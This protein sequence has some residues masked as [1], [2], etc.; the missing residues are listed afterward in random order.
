MLE[1][2]GF[3]R[4]KFT[5]IPKPSEAVTRMRAIVE[6][7]VLLD[8]AGVSVVVDRFHL[9]EAVY[10][11][12]SRDERVNVDEIDKMCSDAGFILFYMHSSAENMMKRGYEAKTNINIHALIGA[13][14]IE[15]FR[16]NMQKYKIS[17]EG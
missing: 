8:K 3:K 14:E 4:L 6:T 16:S 5:T 13:Y 2:A 10:S 15:F 12:L 17:F 11:S 1:A 7:L 9:T